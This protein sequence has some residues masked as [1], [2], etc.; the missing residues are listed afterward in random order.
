MV[1]AACDGLRGCN[2]VEHHCQAVHTSGS[3]SN[4]PRVPHEAPLDTAV[5]AVTGNFIAFISALRS[6]ADVERRRFWAAMR[7]PPE[8]LN[9]A[10]YFT[11]EGGHQAFAQQANNTGGA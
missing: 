2:I 1:F 7:L 9:G 6:G 4:S 10:Q 8:A 11:K 3:D 5:E